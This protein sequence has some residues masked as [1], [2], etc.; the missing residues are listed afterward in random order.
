MIASTDTSDDE[1]VEPSRVLTA[2]RRAVA[3]AC[4]VS[5][6]IARGALTERWGAIDPHSALKHPM[7]GAFC[8]GCMYSADGGVQEFVRQCRTVTSTPHFRLVTADRSEIRSMEEFESGDQLHVI[9]VEAPASSQQRECLACQ[10]GFYQDSEQVARSEEALDNDALTALRN[11]PRDLLS[12]IQDRQRECSPPP[13]GAGPVATNPF[14][15][16]GC[17]YHHAAYNEFARAPTGMTMPHECKRYAGCVH[18]FLGTILPVNYELDCNHPDRKLYSYF[19]QNPPPL[20]KREAVIPLPFVDGEE[21]F[22]LTTLLRSIVEAAQF[23]HQTKSVVRNFNVMELGAGHMPYL[24]RAFVGARQKGLRLRAVGV[25]LDPAD[26]LG[27]KATA[28]LNG[29]RLSVHQAFENVTWD[30]VDVH[31]FESAVVR[32]ASET[33]AVWFE[34]WQA[35]TGS[36]CP[37][38]VVCSNPVDISQLLTLF[39]EP[40]DFL[41]VYLIGGADMVK[42][43][44]HAM[45]ALKSR[46]RRVVVRVTGVKASA[47]NPA[48]QWASWPANCSLRGRIVPKTNTGCGDNSLYIEEY[49]RHGWEIE[50][51]YCSWRPQRTVAGELLQRDGIISLINPRFQSS[52]P[53]FPESVQGRDCLSQPRGTD[54]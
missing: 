4:W 24:A 52:I 32:D 45:E 43:H 29:M 11:S 16:K 10:C 34:R 38:G 17:F 9:A 48:F 46:V 26:T 53:A 7:D 13:E 44:A 5:E 19:L 33:R 27:A 47:G 25:D 39:G 35:V 36:S 20:L 12:L 28:D 41:F 37:H 22:T 18:D 1:T 3:A 6:S 8:C 49:Q 15:P 2:V 31:W 51:S 42:T 23:H 40:V 21:Y 54:N 50:F 30:D 14:A